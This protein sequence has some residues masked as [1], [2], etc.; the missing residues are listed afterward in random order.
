MDS[1]MNDRGL[2]TELLVTVV[3]LLALAG[4]ARLAGEVHAAERVPRAAHDGSTWTRVTAAAAGVKVRTPGD[5]GGRC[6]LF[7]DGGLMLAKQEDGKPFCRA[8]EFKNSG[9]WT[10]KWLR[11]SEGGLKSVETRCIVYGQKQNMKQGWTKFEGNP[12]IC[13]HD[14]KHA[15]DQ[16][17]QLPA[18]HSDWANDQSLVRGA[19]D[20]ES[21]WLLFFNIGSWAV[22]G[23]GVAVADELA[24]LKKGRNPFSLYRPYPLHPGTAGRNAPNDWIYA[25]GILWSPDETKR[26]DSHMWSSENLAEWTN[27]GVI[28]GMVGHDPGLCYDGRRF[29]LF[30]EKGHQIALCTATDPTEKWEYKGEV[31]D[32]GGHTGDADVNFFNNRWHVFFDDDPHG[33][34]QLGYAWTTPSEFPYGWRV[35][36][37]VYGPHNPEQGQVW[38]DDTE[39]GNRFGSG[40][41]DVAVEGTTL[42]LTHE[43]P[44]GMAW[45]EMD[46]LQA[47]EQHV[48]LKLEADRDG[49]GTADVSTEWHRISP[50]E[51]SWNVNMKPVSRKALVRLKARL[52]TENP[53]ESPLLTDLR[54]NF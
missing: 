52:R 7:G 26:D 4:V 28:Q 23:W 10:S 38:D 1:A 46:V 5:Y 18:E 35:T 9:T 41:A 54:I 25:K 49:D 33:H 31:L 29:Y 19:G 47:D 16:S 51:K 24:P 20:L 34:Y 6:D 44:V 11:A 2:Q 40:D 15:T 39:E 13:P 50:G 12:L 37:H 30:N 45:R 48:A 8:D 3:G 22:K 36:H 27:E 32:A 42:Y 17:L 21:K 43:R 53:Q 14:W